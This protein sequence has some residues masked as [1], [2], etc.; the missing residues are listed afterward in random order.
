MTLDKP[1]GLS[2]L[3][4]GLTKNREQNGNPG[5]GPNRRSIMKTSRRTA[6]ARTIQFILVGALAALPAAASSIF[7]SV[8]VV[9]TG[10]LGGTSFTNQLVTFTQVTDTTLIGNCP[11]ETFPCAPDVDTNT[12]TIATVGTFT[13]TSGTFFFDNSMNVFGI[14][15]SSSLAGGFAFLAAEDN[16]F[17]TYNMLSDFGP[18]P[19]GL[20]SCT[21]PFTGLATSGGSLAI[22]SFEPQAPV[23]AQAGT[24]SSSSAPEPGS[25]GLVLAGAIPLAAGLLRRR[26][27]VSAH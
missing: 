18:T 12:V 26:K 16:S 14:T 4:P 11:S 8:G 6:T 21:A 17:G 24:P 22:S 19:Y 9:A 25:L 15:N 1:C 5:L 10:S 20:C 7:Y 13:L 23:T 2:R 3:L 27:R